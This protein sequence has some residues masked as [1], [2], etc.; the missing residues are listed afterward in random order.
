MRQTATIG[1]SHTAL[2]VMGLFGIGLIGAALY[3]FYGPDILGATAGITEC[4][5]ALPIIYGGY[6]SLK[7]DDFTETGSSYYGTNQM[8]GK[9]YWAKVLA[10]G[11]NGCST[12]YHRIE[13]YDKLLY[14]ENAMR[15]DIATEL[16]KWFDAYRATADP[17]TGLGG[18]MPSDLIG[19]TQDST[20]LNARCAKGYI[21]DAQIHG[22]YRVRAVWDANQDPITKLFTEPVVGV[23]AAMN[24]VGEQSIQLG[25]ELTPGVYCQ[26]LGTAAMTITTAGGTEYRTDLKMGQAYSPPPIIIEAIEE[27]EDEGEVIKQIVVLPAEV[28]EE[29]PEL[30]DW[31]ETQLLVDD[32]GEPDVDTIQNRMFW[33]SPGN[34]ALAVLGGLGL[35]MVTVFATVALTGQRSR[36]GR[37]WRAP[38]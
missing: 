25:D 13:I 38:F 10:T 8:A 17:S 5:D 32:K 6:S 27:G 22:I 19:V 3:G 31:W 30:V 7:I 33:A 12:I 18:E 15:D 28:E 24:M 2:L 1:T 11:D 20:D 37:A 35:I 26:K 34:I 36:R 29:Q 9:Q 14:V 4:G 16:K 21:E 23:F